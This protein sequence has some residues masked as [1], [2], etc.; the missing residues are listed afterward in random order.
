MR[1]LQLELLLEILNGWEDQEK[2]N[3]HERIEELMN[4]KEMFSIARQ[5]LDTVVLKSFTN[6]NVTE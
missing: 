4:G 5:Y 6:S 2:I 3:F 1:D